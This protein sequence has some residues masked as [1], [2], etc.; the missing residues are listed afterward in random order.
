MNV[1]CV[2][3]RLAFSPKLA[4]SLR[5]GWSGLLLEVERQTED[6]GDEP[7][8]VPVTVVLPPKLANTKLSG[9]HPGAAI[10]VVGRLDVEVD[11]SFK[12]PRAYHSVVA[13]RIET[14]SE[15]PIGF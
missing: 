10:S 9:L 8:V 3:G 1:V 15:G 6:G 12:T 4:V 14:D 5:P 2:S 11:H 13:Q 7:G